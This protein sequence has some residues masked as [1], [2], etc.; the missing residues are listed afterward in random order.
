MKKIF[1][2]FL[3]VAIIFSFA[4]GVLGEDEVVYGDVNYDGR[5]NLYDVSEILKY[6]SKW[7]MSEVVFI[8]DAAD[9]THDGNINLHDVSKILKYMA[10][11]YLIDLGPC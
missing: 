11:W 4:A 3:I 8:E 9:V 6:I 1:V 2:V 7:N 5:I 10:K